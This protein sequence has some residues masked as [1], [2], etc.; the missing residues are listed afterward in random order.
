MIKQTIIK[1][2]SIHSIYRVADTGSSSSPHT[3][4]DIIIVES[5]KESQNGQ[6]NNDVACNH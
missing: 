2:H 4:V 6:E 5:Y 3:V 1:M